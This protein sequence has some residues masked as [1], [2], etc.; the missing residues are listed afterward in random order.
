MQST[1]YWFDHLKT[2]GLLTS[3]WAQVDQVQFLHRPQL[4]SNS[5]DHLLDRSGHRDSDGGV[6]VVTAVDFEQNWRFEPHEVMITEKNPVTGPIMQRVYLLSSLPLIGWRFCGFSSPKLNC[7]RKTLC[8]GRIQQIQVLKYISKKK[9][10]E[11]FDKSKTG[12]F[13]TYLFLGGHGSFSTLEKNHKS[14]FN[15]QV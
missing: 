7:R 12:T 5:T 9:K 14:N 13:L 4:I 10:H 6:R 11:M 8:C 3:S 2:G 15:Y 1:V